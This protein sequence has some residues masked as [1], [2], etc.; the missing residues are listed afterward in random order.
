MT[1][2]GLSFLFIGGCV[3]WVY[4]AQRALFVLNFAQQD[5]VA[6]RFHTHLVHWYLLYGAAA[7]FVGVALLLS[8]TVMII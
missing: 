2:W 8:V 4:G 6:R 3:L 7:T 5:E 1:L